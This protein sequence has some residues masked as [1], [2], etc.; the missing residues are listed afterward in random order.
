MKIEP[1]NK[2]DHV[3]WYFSTNKYT[4]EMEYDI[5]Y[6]IIV[7]LE[8]HITLTNDNFIYAFLEK[9]VGNNNQNYYALFWHSPGLTWMLIQ[10]SNLEI[11]YDKSFN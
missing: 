6:E 4:S 9:Y 5:F 7:H 8:S 1:T 10:P 11:C 2:L 3:G